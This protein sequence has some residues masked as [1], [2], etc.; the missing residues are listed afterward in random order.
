MKIKC[1]TLLA[2]LESVSPGLAADLGTDQ[3]QFFLFHDGSV[4]TYNGEIACSAACGVD[5]E[6]AVVAA[7]L[8]EALKRMDGEIE[9]SVEE[10]ELRIKCGRKRAGIRMA[11]MTAVPQASMKIPDKFFK[12]PDDFFDAIAIVA[13]C[14]LVKHN[15]FILMCVNIAPDWVE[16]SDSFKAARYMMTTSLS[17]PILVRKTSIKKL[18]GSKVTHV[19]QSK[20]WIHFKATND[21]VVSCRGYVE[22]YPDLSPLF[23]GVGKKLVLPPEISDAVVGASKFSDGSI[24]IELKSDKVR[25]TGRGD[26]A[27]LSEVLDCKWDGEEFKF[28]ATEAV[29]KEVVKKS[30][31]VQ[32][33]DKRLKATGKNWVFISCIGR[34]KELADE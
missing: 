16:A 6:G 31:K 2:N 19:A 27:W 30:N 29:L 34:V 26:N 14:A 28:S 7:E 23:E 13:D 1:S 5:F 22:K 9:L 20:D 8:M 32:M 17:S 11:K 18:A 12:L 10:G 4:R 3:S 25:V 15:R 21:L 33:T 24:T